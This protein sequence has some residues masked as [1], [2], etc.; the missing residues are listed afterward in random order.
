[1]AEA[2]FTD[3]EPLDTDR[4]DR[5]VDDVD[6][7]VSRTSFTLRFGLSRMLDVIG[8]LPPFLLFRLASF[9]DLDLE[10]R[11]TMLQKMDRSR[12]APLALMLV[13]YKTLMTMCWYE[14]P[15]RLAALGYPGDLARERYKRLPM[16]R[17]TSEAAQ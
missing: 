3:D 8:F 17:A 9:D 11:V 1:M 6:D 16:A 4:L 15:E 13:A 5:F 10:E 12:F 2:L 7:H 14:A